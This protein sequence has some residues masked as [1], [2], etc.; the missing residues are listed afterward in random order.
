[1]LLETAVSEFSDAVFG[2]HADIPL[3]G[4]LIVTDV[5]GLT[6]DLNPVPVTVLMDV[7]MLPG[8][9]PGVLVKNHQNGSSSV[10]TGVNP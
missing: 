5:Q 4:D 10:S 7:P 1:M 8:L 3:A 9:L 6:D 2:V